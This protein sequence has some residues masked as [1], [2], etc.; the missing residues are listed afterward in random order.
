MDCPGYNLNDAE[1]CKQASALNDVALALEQLGFKRDAIDKVL[2]SLA[3]ELPE[4]E[5]P[6]GE[7]LLRSAIRKLS[8]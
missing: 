3:A 2:K 4:G 5:K 7:K 1:D 6:D 8:F